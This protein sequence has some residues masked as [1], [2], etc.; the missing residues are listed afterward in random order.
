MLLAAAP[1][2]VLLFASSSKYMRSLKAIIGVGDDALTHLIG[3]LLLFLVLASGFLAA[4]RWVLGERSPDWTRTFVAAAVAL[5]LVI[6]PLLLVFPSL[7]ELFLQ[8]SLYDLVNANEST[9]VDRTDRPW[10]LT[11]AAKAGL[12]TGFK[13]GVAVYGLLFLLLLGLAMR[14]NGRYRLR[15]GLALQVVSG[16][17]LFYLLFVARW[18]FATGIAVTFRATVFAYVLA[19]ILGLV[20]SGLQALRPTPRT[21][22]VYATTSMILIAVATW[23]WLQPRDAYVFVGNTDARIAIIKDTPQSLA[24]TIRFGEYPGGEGQSLRIRNVPDAQSALEQV[25]TSRNVS[26]AL[27][28][29]STHDGSLPAIWQTEVL[30]NSAKMPAIVLTAIGALLLVLTFGAAQ[31]GLHPLAVGSEFFVDTIRGIP[32]LVIILYVGLP[33]SGAVKDATSGSIDLPNMTRGIIAIAVGYS[34]YM[35][36]IFRAGIEAVPSGQTEAGKSL[37]LTRVQMARLIVLPQA[38]RIVIPPLGNEFIA[39]IKDTSLLS[40]LSVRDVTQ[41]TREFQASSFL[42]FAPF[43]TAAILYVVITL[44]CAS[45]LK[46]IERRYDTSRN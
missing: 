12:M 46:W 22:F 5:H 14:E 16:L 35:A 40:I 4:R 37:G 9:L 44:A 43:N 39:M 11:S 2:I 28:P 23:F 31:H 42:P 25:A 7:A 17:L 41:R 20:W 30:P 10:V 32:M 19:A 6:L 1:F 8:A 3:F 33:L 27:I 36:E 24:D 21:T 15:A 26:G 45:F 34:A 38:L 13:V 18:E 29:A